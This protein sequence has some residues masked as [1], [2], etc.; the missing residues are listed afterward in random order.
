[1]VQANFNTLIY[2]FQAYGVVDFL[3]PFL[4][5]FTIVYAVS[6][7]IDWLNENKNFRM[8]I[9]VVV[10]LLFVIPHVMGTYPLGYDPVQVLNESLPSIS[11]VIIAAVMML[12]LLGL[13]GAELREKGTTFVGIASIAF[14][15]YIFGASLRF[16]RAPYDIFSWWSSQ[17]TELIIILLIFGLI[18]RFITGDDHG[19]N[20][21]SG[22]NQDA[23]D[24]RVAAART[25][26]RAEQ[27]TYVGR[28]RNE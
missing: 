27:S 23:Y 1:M 18:V 28:R 9:A 14:V 2:Y 10:G 26:R 7:R 4:L 20:R 11:L 19:V 22:E 24:T 3:L 21:G 5:V 25:A 16:W 15:V 6:S 17:T 13:F 12:I 8:V